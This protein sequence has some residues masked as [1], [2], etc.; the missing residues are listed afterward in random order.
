MR[1]F[2]RVCREGS[3]EGSRSYR[4]R[5]AEPARIPA[6]EF[7]D[8]RRHFGGSGIFGGDVVARHWAAANGFTAADEV[9]IVRHDCGDVAARIARHGPGRRTQRSAAGRKPRAR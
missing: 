7:A 5:A 1:I 8:Y 4:T 6:A 3:Y 9:G 2:V